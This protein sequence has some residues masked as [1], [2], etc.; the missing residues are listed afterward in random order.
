V[1]LV[2]GFTKAVTD[3]W[4]S[5]T[6]LVLLGVAVV[7]LSA[8]VLA[9]SHSRHP[10][11]PLRVILERNRGGAYLASLLT[12]AGLF[13]MF[14]FLS[15]Y[16]QAVLHYSALRAGLAYLPFPVMAVFAASAS[17]VLVPKTGPRLPMALGLLTAAVGMAWMTTIGAHTSYGAHVLP[18]LGVMGAGIGLSYPAIASTALIKVRDDDAGVAS[19]LV[20]TTQQV[21]GSLGIAL[22]N[23]V[24]V[25]VTANYLLA[26]GVTSALGGLVKGYQVAFVV[27]AG[28]L[29]LGALVSLVFVQDRPRDV[30][31]ELDRISVAPA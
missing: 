17:T 9:E 14:I 19:A 15:Y 13:A 25:T 3:G 6:T 5:A 28:I 29:L 27:S 1:S 11:L 21:G 8:F 2:Y 20:N 24:A 23:T 31:A 18:A 26:H 16:L 4:G 22:L 12:G 7:L 30:E 10:L